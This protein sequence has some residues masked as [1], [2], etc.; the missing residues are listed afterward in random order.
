MQRK[1]GDE[2]AGDYVGARYSGKFQ[3][4]SE[5]DGVLSWVAIGQRPHCPASCCPFA[6]IEPADPRGGS[7]NTRAESHLPC[8]AKRT[9]RRKPQAT[10]VERPLAA[11]ALRVPESVGNCIVNFLICFCLLWSAGLGQRLSRFSELS[12]DLK[13]H[14]APCI[15][16]LQG[17]ALGEEVA[18]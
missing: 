5:R 18:S 12:A 13:C 1:P 15:F 11:T 16:D 9:P 10:N 7:P 17:F 2:G 6:L 14:M 3:L 8:H 4:L